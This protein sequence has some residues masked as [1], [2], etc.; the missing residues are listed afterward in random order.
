MGQTYRI[1]RLRIITY[2]GKKKKEMKS[3]RCRYMAKSQVVNCNAQSQLFEFVNFRGS[4]FK[5]VNFKNAVF[6]GCDFWGTTFKDCD[7]QNAKFQDCVFMASI[8]RNCGFIGTAF[9]NSVIVNTKLP[10]C[11]S[12]DKCS[13]VLLHSTYPKCDMTIELN[14]ALETLRDNRNL[15]KNKLL[16][17]SDTKYNQLNLFLLQGQY[18]NRLP[19]LLL[20]LNHHSTAK[21]TTYKK[22]ERELNKLLKLAIM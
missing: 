11:L 13:G 16:F 14:T 19:A 15:K 7:F 12:I 17:I 5:N 3:L 22:M 8:L 21:I 1:D 18:H 4:H 10:D 20:E 9:S 2:K 6:Y